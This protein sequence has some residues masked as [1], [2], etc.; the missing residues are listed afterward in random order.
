MKNKTR[1]IIIAA[2]IALALLTLLFIFGNSL[3]DSS[4][5]SEQSLAVKKILTE[6]A[7]IFGFRGDINIALLRN[8]AHVAEFCMLG[9]CFSTLAIYLAR[10]QNPCSLLRSSSFVGASVFAGLVIAIIDELIQLMS[11]GRACEVKD[12]VLDMTG[13]IIGAIIACVAYFL[14]IKIRSALQK[15]KISK[16]T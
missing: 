10:R 8:L 14:L 5:S 15:D 2:I 12:V 1:K 11:E 4:E 6:I 9:V 3:K 16:N 7:S 13:I